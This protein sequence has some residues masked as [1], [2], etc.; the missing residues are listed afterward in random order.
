MKTL[1]KPTV[2]WLLEWYRNNGRVVPHS[3]LPNFWSEGYCL[4]SSARLSSS[5]LVKM[6]PTNAR[7]SGWNRN[8]SKYLAAMGEDVPKEWASIIDEIG[9]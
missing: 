1:T 5:F 8:P 7:E 3:Q 9:H 4:W 2:R 6:V